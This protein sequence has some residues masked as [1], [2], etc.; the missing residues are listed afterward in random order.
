MKKV[1]LALLFVVA[2]G[3]FQ[4]LYATVNAVDK[5]PTFGFSVMMGGRYDNMRMCIASPAGTPGG[6]VA[7]VAFFMRFKTSPHFAFSLSVPVFRPILFGAAFHMLQYES[8]V[9]FEF[10]VPVSDRVDFV[11]GPGIG[12]SYHYGPDYFADKDDD[13]AEK[14]FALGPMVS[15]YAAFDFKWPGNYATRV[16]IRLFHVSLFRTDEFQ[17]GLVL[18]GA[19]TVGM[20]F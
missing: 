15:Y 8:D 12:V 7:D 13:N 20:Y 16:G 9:A 6:M 1:F 19:V 17:Y 10:S 5:T 4:P 3:S 18:G 11:T 2:V 14:F